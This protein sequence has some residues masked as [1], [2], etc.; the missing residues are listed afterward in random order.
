MSTAIKCAEPR[1]FRSRFRTILN[2]E[3]S[4]F[5][6]SLLGYAFCRW[7]IRTILF[8][9]IVGASP[10]LFSGP[11][12][13]GSAVQLSPLVAE[14]TLIGPLDPNRQISVVLVLP[15]SDPQGAAN[16]V[17]HL[18]TPGDPLYHHYLTPEQFAERF[19]GNASDYAALREWATA[20]GLTV[21]QESTARIDLTV[22]GSV[23]Q[24]ENIFSTQINT[25]RS[26]S[27]EEFYSAAVKPI[28]PSA[29]SAKVFCVIG[30]TGSK[31]YAA[32]VKIGKLL[33]AAAADVSAELEKTNAGP[34]GTGP[35]GS[36]APAD[37]R[38]A[39]T[40]PLFGKFDDRTVVGVFEQGGFDASDVTEYLTRFKLPQPKVTAVSVDGSP[41]GV[42]DPNVELE[43]VLD[44]D[45]VIGINPSIHEVRVYE[46]STDYF[47][48]A[49]LDAMTQTAN[50]DKVQILSISYGQ[51]EYLQGQDA[52]NAENDALLQLAS[53]G[54]TVLAS[55]GDNGAYG[56]L[57]NGVYNVSDPATQPYITA[58][59]GTTLLT[60]PHQE[61]QSEH[62]WNDLAIY[63][64]ADGG[65]ISSVWS[66]PSWQVGA[67]PAVNGG[68]DTMR[69]VPDIAAVGDP[70]TGVGIYSKI[71]GGWVQVG[72]TSVAAPIWASYLSLVNAGAKFAGLGRLGYFNPTLYNIGAA[73]DGV[74]VPWVWLN[75]VETGSNGSNALY[76]GYPGYSAG[77]A[78]DDCKGN[79]SLSG[80]VLPAILIN[81]LNESLNGLNSAWAVPTDRSV[82]IQ[83]DKAVGAT[84]Y[85]V[86]VDHTAGASAVGVANVYAT[87][88]ASLEVTGLIPDTVYFAV[89]FA[90]SPYGFQFNYLYFTTK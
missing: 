14:S 83:W 38:A 81:N 15:L 35:G 73:I 85:F 28:V 59:G 24:F 16:F 67:E 54:I 58:V 50:E 84:A 32:L 6:R 1:N 43:A 52:I 57:S 64:G 34:G 61:Y 87:K 75:D 27:E 56:D 9:A 48:V 19:G 31:Q 3:A 29:I 44:I 8:S 18:S 30:L 7:R 78:Y 55:S 23:A 45:M 42:S 82:L 39:Y 20:N 21:S 37:L 25:Y 10:V 36:Y 40:I 70:L 4:A 74:P 17:R 80:S 41:T 26:P 77:Y 72:G 89:V 90:V 2:M 46:D 69:N 60:G 53:E 33:G 63:L 62:I 76:T 68:S 65:G 47:Q 51:D 66:I 5:L 86:T 11:L 88:T 79:G 71:N 49:L 22:R 13:A 12:F